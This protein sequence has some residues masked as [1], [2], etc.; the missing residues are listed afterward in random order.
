[1]TRREAD[2]PARGPRAPVSDAAVDACRRG[3]RDA[4]ERVFREECPALQR[5]IAR[6]VGPGPDVDDLLQSTLVTA[7]GAFPRFRGQASVRT[8]LT[9]IAIR[10]VHGHL[11]RPDRT[12]RV[13][14]QAITGEP[15]STEAPLDQRADAR[16]RLERLHDHLDAIDPKQRIAFV[17]HVIEGRPIDEVA[18]LVD[19]TKTATRSRVFWARL[20][21]M[22]RLRRDPWFHD[23]APP[24]GEP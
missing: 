19:A 7:I 11:R 23:V 16:R 8:W 6:M 9:G 1:M 10:V 3:D 14:L 21:L 17:L 4:L 2:T 18:A 5:T 13:P 20:R 15:A 12:R 22:T 24:G